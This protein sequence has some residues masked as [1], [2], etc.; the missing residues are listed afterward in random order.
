[1]ILGSLRKPI[2]RLITPTCRMLLRWG[3]SP[4]LMTTIGAIGLTGSALYFF[5][6][7]R[8][9]GGTLWVTAFV[10]SDVFDGTMARLSEKGGSQ[11]G[12]ILDSTLDRI[13]D[14]AVL[15]GMAL[16]FIR[17]HDSLAWVLIFSLFAS[18]LISYIKARA[19]G[20]GLTCEG[21]LMERTERLVLILVAAGVSGLGVSYLF[22]VS[23]WVLAVGSAITC[24]QRSLSVYNSAHSTS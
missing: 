5:P 18:F 20:V 4:N 16:Y 24:I 13:G 15:G 7:G 10:F 21:G 23:A 9:F 12:A 6:Q 3:I 19:E 1:M 22:A 14:A 17:N 8:F 11:W 2:G